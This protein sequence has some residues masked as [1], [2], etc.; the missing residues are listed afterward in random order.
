[1]CLVRCRCS[2]SS[3]EVAVF[4]LELNSISDVVVNV[5]DADGGS[6]S[7]FTTGECDNEDSEL[8][9]YGI[10]LDN[11]VFTSVE[12]LLLVIH[13]SGF[14]TADSF[15]VDIQINPITPMVKIMIKMV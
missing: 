11:R 10:G 5:T 12:V 7:V 13:R 15:T 4:T 6:S 3:G 1:M 14:A 8:A 9:C 2:F